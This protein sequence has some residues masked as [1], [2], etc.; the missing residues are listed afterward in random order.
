MRHHKKRTAVRREAAQRVRHCTAM[1]YIKGCRRLVSDHKLCA[2][3]ERHSDEGALEHAA[4]EF[5]RPLYEHRIHFGEP[6]CF[7][8][9]HAACPGFRLLLRPRQPQQ[10]HHLRPHTLLRRPGCHRI[11]RHKSDTAAIET[12]PNVSLKREQIIPAKTQRAA[13]GKSLR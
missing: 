9:L 10:A 8:G 7:A 1:Q 4:G 13:R 12:A 2:H 11:L 5:V 6:R 3:S